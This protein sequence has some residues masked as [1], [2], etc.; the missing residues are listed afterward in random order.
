MPRF[1]KRMRRFPECKIWSRG[2]C[3]KG[4]TCKYDHTGPGSLQRE[5][6]TRRPRNDNQEQHI[7]IYSSRPRDRSQESRPFRQRSRSRP[8]SRSRSY[9]DYRGS[10][11]PPPPHERWRERSTSR[12]NESS[13]ARGTSAGRGS[14]RT[15]SGSD[16]LALTERRA[17]AATAPSRG[18]PPP[19]I[20]RCPAATHAFIPLLRC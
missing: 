8:R 7:D 3:E 13:Q 6:L 17:D 15:P 5:I 4:Y 20:D 1:R 11:R 10:D 14:G 12:G 18:A 2:A 16:D 19:R 9:S